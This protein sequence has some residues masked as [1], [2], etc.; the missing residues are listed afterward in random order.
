MNAKTPSWLNKNQAKPTSHA[1]A[2]SATQ[3]NTPP[4]A[5]QP[6]GATDALSAMLWLQDDDGQGRA[7][8]YAH[9][10]EIYTDTH[11]GLLRLFLP[12]SV[13]DIITPN[14]GALVTLLGRRKLASLTSGQL[15]DDILVKS[16]TLYNR[17]KLR[18]TDDEG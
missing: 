13:A 16:V 4:A 14:M 17:D 2:I 12:R 3:D 9:I 18:H 8:N 1:A 11:R 5:S 10:E 15:N 7:V 6:L